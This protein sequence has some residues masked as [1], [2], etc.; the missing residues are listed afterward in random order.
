VHSR[1]QRHTYTCTLIAISRE[2]LRPGVVETRSVRRDNVTVFREENNIGGY[3]FFS[4]VREY[5]MYIYLRVHTSRTRAPIRYRRGR[6]GMTYYI[7]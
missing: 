4:R 6:G 2:V 5:N 7:I 1:T 3:V